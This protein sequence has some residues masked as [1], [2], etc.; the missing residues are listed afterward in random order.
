MNEAHVLKALRKERRDAMLTGCITALA[1][2]LA[3]FFLCKWGVAFGRMYFEAAHPDG[4]DQLKNS[5]SDGGMELFLFFIVVVLPL[6]CAGLAVKLFHWVGKAFHA[7]PAT[8]LKTALL[9]QSVEGRLPVD[10]L[11]RQLN[12]SPAQLRREIAFFD[13]LNE[14]QAP[15][16]MLDNPP[17]IAVS[18]RSSWLID[19]EKK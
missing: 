17:V 8:A 11:P 2:L 4:L 18:L 10:E 19:A 6:G 12:L 7:N 14:H 9:L 3:A 15:A 16:P 5:R 13:M 1:L